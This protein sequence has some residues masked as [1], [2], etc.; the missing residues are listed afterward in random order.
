MATFLSYLDV[1]WIE[2]AR[3]RFV[4][5][6]FDTDIRGLSVFC[7]AGLWQSLAGSFAF[8]ISFPVI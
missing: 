5:V 8:D 7:R 1:D 6:K 4:S 2:L 3:D